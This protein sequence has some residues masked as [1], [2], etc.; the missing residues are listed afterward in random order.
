MYKSIPTSYSVFHKDE[1]PI[2]GEYSTHVEIDDEA[3]GGFVVLKQY[4]D[5]GNMTIKLD[6]EEL[7][8]VFR[9]SNKLL[10]AYDAITKEQEK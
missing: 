5:E 7:E 8:E 1:N 9:L 4:T 10:A 3:A 2:F 6:K